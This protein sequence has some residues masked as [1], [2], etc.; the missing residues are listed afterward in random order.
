MRTL[1]LINPN[2]SHEVTES[3]QR[4]VATHLGAGWQVCAHTAPFGAPYIACQTSYT[5][6]AHAAVAVYRQQVLSG[7]RPDAVLVACFGDPGV[8][9]L[10]VLAPVPIYGLAEA[11]MRRVSQKGR[12][13]VVT[14]GA[15]WRPM[16]ARLV[17]ALGDLK[18]PTDIYT[19]SLSGADIMRQPQRSAA[20]LANE[21][22]RAGDAGAQH[23]LLGGAGLAG[24]SPLL[25]ARVTLPVHDSVALSAEAIAQQPLADR[26]EVTQDSWLAPLHALRWWPEDSMATS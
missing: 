1:L 20:L 26:V 16:L 7:V 17:R 23:V 2:T 14:G 19:V 15:A 21:I 13:A 22:A 9:A 4:I 24:L 18:A 5:V 25:Q 10:R 11:S 8:E 6:G 12:F 3:L